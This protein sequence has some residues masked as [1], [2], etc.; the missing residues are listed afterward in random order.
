MIWP[1]LVS[2]FSRSDWR[3]ERCFSAS[4]MRHISTKAS[5][6]VLLP[7][8][9]GFAANAAISFPIYFWGPHVLSRKLD[10][11]LSRALPVVQC[12][13]DRKGNGAVVVSAVYT[14]LLPVLGYAIS[15]VGFVVCVV[16]LL[17]IRSWRLIVFLP[18]LLSLRLYVLLD[19]LAGLP[20]PSGSVFR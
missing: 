17:S 9:L 7:N 14:L 8:Q 15:T 13:V 11:R 20:L 18:I 10:P 6:T 5:N 4:L 2:N 12:D 3:S 1:Y 19:V 16:L